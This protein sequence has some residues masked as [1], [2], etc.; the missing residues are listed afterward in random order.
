[1]LPSTA[2]DAIRAVVR[3]A[4]NLR[5]AEAIFSDIYR[6]NSWDDPDSA[7]GPGSNLE[8][9][10]HV[11]ATLPGLIKKYDVASVLD[12]PCGDLFWIIQSIP[13]EIRYIGGDIVPE[14]VERNR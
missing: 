9:T 8:A 3:H 14:I 7:S 10:R 11:R 4:K 1:M 2:A 5:S 12:V 13:S 6:A